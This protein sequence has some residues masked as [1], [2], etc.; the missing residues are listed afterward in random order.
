MA[1]LKKKELDPAPVGSGSSSHSDHLHPRG[2]G[3]GMHETHDFYTNTV[4]RA[5]GT[6]TSLYGKVVD[7]PIAERVTNGILMKGWRALLFTNRVGLT[8]KINY[9]GNKEDFMGENLT[10]K[11]NTGSLGNGDHRTDIYLK[12]HLIVKGSIF[13][14]EHG[15]LPIFVGHDLMGLFGEEGRRS[16]FTVQYSDLLGKTTVYDPNMLNQVILYNLT[17]VTNGD[18]QPFI[19][20]QIR[21]SEIEAKPETSW[22]AIKSMGRNTPMYHY[23]G[24]EDSIQINTSWYMPKMPGEPGF[25]PYWVINQ[26]RRLKSWAMANGYTAGPPVI[27][28]EWGRADIFRD[29]LWILTS[30][31][32]HLGNFSDRVVVKENIYQDDGEF[33]KCLPEKQVKLIDAGLVPFAATQELI[34]KRVS[35]HSLLSAEIYNYQEPESQTPTE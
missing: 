10:G 5:M 3:Y 26:C 9:A 22:A 15:T 32:Y 1:Q 28:I 12:N 30:A 13:R 21:P 20:L 18:P 23:L 19:A 34:F 7:N 2:W 27:R 33:I 25:N 14:N 35:S 29:E 4:G 6:V 16:G 8:H 11:L 31:T 24:A 17:E